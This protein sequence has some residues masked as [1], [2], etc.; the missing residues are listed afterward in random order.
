MSCSHCARTNQRLPPATA[1]RMYTRDLPLWRR[2]A[3]SCAQLPPPGPRHTALTVICGCSAAES[4]TSGPSRGCRFTGPL[5]LG[6]HDETLLPGRLHGTASPVQRSRIPH[7]VVHS[8]M[9]VCRIPHADTRS[10]AHVQGCDDP[11]VAASS[12]AYGSTGR[13]LEWQLNI[14]GTNATTQNG[15]TTVIHELGPQRI[16]MDRNNALCVVLANHESQPQLKGAPLLYVI[17]CCAPLLPAHPPHAAHLKRCW[18]QAQMHPPCSVVRIEH[19]RRSVTT[20]HCVACRRRLHS[21]LCFPFV[22]GHMSAIQ[23]SFPAAPAPRLVH[24]LVRPVLCR[25]CVLGCPLL[26]SACACSAS[27]LEHL[28]CP[29]W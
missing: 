18:G 3:P 25:S 20:S 14:Q 13:R 21:E 22:H 9:C 5:W 12:S 4:R 10:V 11:A 17:A 19:S 1:T 29:H 6:C 8:A 2:G 24:R 7:A 27:S 16:L 28:S 15:I 26:A 23:S